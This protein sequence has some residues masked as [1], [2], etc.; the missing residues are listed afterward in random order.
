MDSHENFSYARVA[1]APSPADSG[2]ELDV[3]LDSDTVFPNVPFNAT[4]W[5]VDTIPLR[6]NAEIIRVTSVSG[7]TL[8]IER[9]AEASNVR[10]IV[11]GDQLAATITK[12]TLTD[13]EALVGA[14]DEAL[15]A[16]VPFTVVVGPDYERGDPH[17]ARYMVVEDNSRTIIGVMVDGDDFPQWVLTTDGSFVFGHFG[18][19]PLNPDPLI[20]RQIV[21]FQPSG[22]GWELWGGGSHID[23][24]EETVIVE[25]QW[26]DAT[27][28]PGKWEFGASVVVV[29]HGNAEPDDTLL[30]NSTYTTWLDDTPGQTALKIKAK[31]SAGTV[32]TATVPLS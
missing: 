16:A 8:T 9:G 19:D 6:T 26:L 14:G 10:E 4:V 31:D 1:V 7:E 12:Q 28:G 13:I 24:G 30:N 23:M 3:V 5:P 32:R 2:T 18:T 11:A 17:T 29:N 21:G 25:Y 20:K 22:L 27:T 15:P